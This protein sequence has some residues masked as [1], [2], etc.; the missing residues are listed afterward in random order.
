MQ[1]NFIIYQIVTIIIETFKDC[2]TSCRKNIEKVWSRYG[3]KIKIFCRVPKKSTRQNGSLPSAGVGNSAKL[4]SLPR[5][6]RAPLGE[7]NGVQILSHVTVVCRVCFFVEGLPLGEKRLRRVPFFAECSAL[8]KIRF[9]DGYS[10][11]RGALGE[12]YLRR[13]PDFEPSAKRLT[14]GDA[15]SSGSCT[16]NDIIK[17]IGH[18]SVHAP[19][20]QPSEQV[21][22]PKG[23]GY[24][25][26]LRCR[27]IS[28]EKNSNARTLPSQCQSLPP[29]S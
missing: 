25:T 7:E 27:V 17:I 26:R 23:D 21:T 9:V 19:C 22:P 5:A 11:P 12:E 20:P 24:F 2:L 13:E 4:G 14:L 1:L 6:L 16:H 15:L 10:L 28:D 3:E 8:G 29:L 18:R